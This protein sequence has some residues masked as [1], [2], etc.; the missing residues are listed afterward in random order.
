MVEEGGG[1]EG[2]EGATVVANQRRPARRRSSKLSLILDLRLT[3]LLFIGL[4]ITMATKTL[5]QVHMDNVV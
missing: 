2:G 4:D 5:T 1:G 3:A